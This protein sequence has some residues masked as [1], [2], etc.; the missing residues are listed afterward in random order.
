LENTAQF[1]PAMGP[2]LRCL[3]LGLAR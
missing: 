1:C 3:W 2:T